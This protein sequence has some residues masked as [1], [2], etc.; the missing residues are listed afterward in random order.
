MKSFVALSLYAL[1]VGLTDALDPSTVSMGDRSAWCVSQKAQCP[2]L[3]L[4]YPGDSAAT[5]SNTCD[6]KTLVYSCVC[7]VNGLAPNMTEYSLTIPYYICQAMNTQ[8]KNACSIGNGGCAHQCDLTHVCGARDP[9]RINT[10]ALA[11]T[12]AST[13]APTATDADGNVIYSGFGGASEPTGSSGQDGGDSNG[14]GVS[15]T[16]AAAGLKVQGPLA[17]M[18]ALVA[19]VGLGFGILA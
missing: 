8:C 16:G 12:M 2:L 7:A 3:C 15:G 5:V 14:G 9:T 10:T 6:P 1:A 17:G 4:Q 13:A 19:A 18:V 11:S